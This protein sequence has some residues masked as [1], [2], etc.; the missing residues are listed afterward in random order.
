[1]VEALKKRLIVRVSEVELDY[2]KHA[3]SLRGQTEA[4]FVREAVNEKLRHMGVDAV[5]LDENRR[6]G[7]KRKEDWE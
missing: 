5:L 6:P 3:A 1:M 7:P 4:A 2:V